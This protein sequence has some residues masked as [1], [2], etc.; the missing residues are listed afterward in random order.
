AD[1]AAI[2][3]VIMS[4]EQDSAMSY[5]KKV[6]ALLRSID[7]VTEPKLSV[8]DGSPEVQVTLDRDKMA[9][10]GLSVDVVGGTMQTAFSGTQ[11]DPKLKF[12]QG[13]Y[14]YDVNL[15]YGNFDRKNIE[16]VRNVMITNSRGENIRL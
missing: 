8:E 14:E 15:R 12:K 11:E 4:A 10:L 13:E 1:R 5:A 9:S 16:D 2:D 7:G 3:L 6:M